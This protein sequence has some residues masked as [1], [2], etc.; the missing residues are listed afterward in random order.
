MAKAVKVCDT[1]T[2][3]RRSITDISELFYIAEYFYAVSAMFIKISIAVT[4][5]RIA[6]I[7]RTI[8]WALWALIFVTVLAALVFVI[9]IAN[10]CKLELPSSCWTM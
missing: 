5:M 4:L 10:I 8:L 2:L 1:D 7:F 6:E 3:Q 9:G